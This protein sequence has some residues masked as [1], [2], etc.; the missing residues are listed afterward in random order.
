MFVC[1]LLLT[2]MMGANTPDRVAVEND[3][4]S[5]ELTA[6]GAIRKAVDKRFGRELLSMPESKSLFR[7]D[8]SEG[9]GKPPKMQTCFARQAER[10]RLEPWSRGAD[11]GARIT[12]SGFSGR[13]IEVVCTVFTR[14]DDGLLHFGLEASLPPDVTLESV[15][16]PIVM[17]GS[18]WS[19]GEK[20]AAVV[21]ATKGGIHRIAA[22]KEGATRRFDQP[23]SLAAG[24]GC[25]YDDAGGVYTAAHDG[26]GHP[27]SLM[28]RRAAAGLEWSWIHP[29]YERR[30]FS[31][32]YDIVMGGFASPQ[33]E[34]STDWRDAADLYKAW[35]AKQ[36]WCAK[37]FDRRDD[38]PAWL[39]QGPAM[40]RFTRAWLA[41]PGSV[42][43]WYR[44]Y[45]QKE[46][47]AHTP[48]IAAYW[49]WEKNGKWVGP[50]Y[51]PAYPSDDQFRRLVQLGREL[52]AHTFLWPS[53]Y[54]YSL[55]YGKRPDG[56]F[57]WDNRRQLDSIAG[58]AV[59][60]RAGKPLVR[61][62]SWL[63]GGQHCVLCP[64]DPWTIDWLNRSAVECAQHGAELVQVDQVVGGRNPPCY[65]REHDHAPGPGPWATASFR[66]QLQSMARQCRAIEPA[67]VLGFEEPN[68]WFLQEIGI[69][70]YRDCD[71]IW[72]GEEPASVFA[73]LYHEYLPTLFQSNRSQTGHDPWALAW[74][75][76][77]GQVPH[78]AP[79]LGL[80]PGPMIVDGGFERSYDEG[81][82]E[83]PRTMMFPGEGWFAGETEIDRKERHS[84]QASLKLYNQT[85]NTRA[86]AAQNYDVTEDFCPGRTYRFSAW[87]RSSQIAKPNGL[88]LKAFA[89]GMNAL[90]SWRISYPADQAQ[91][92]RRQVDFTMPDGTTVL[93]VMLVLDGGGTVWL[94]DL[95]LEEVLPDGRTVEL[96]R[97]EKPAD[98]EFMRQWLSLYQGVGRRYLLLGKMLHPPRLEIGDPVPAGTKRLPPVLHNAFEAP[99][100]SRGV[101]LVNWTTKEQNA[102]LTWKNQ[103][104]AITLRPGEVRWT[105]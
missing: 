20:T 102:K 59:V 105:E 65:S 24:F 21:G 49:G 45:W 47:P 31:L 48:L 85:P 96:Q 69:Q 1:S 56:S 103:I 5:L 100:G 3:R 81:S 36:P 97:P 9:D 101:V 10:V 18:P 53:G 74:C 26:D 19:R 64:G 80:G 75:L 87:I 73:Y 71:L 89:P 44:E 38:L 93:R 7:L 72:S 78:L 94:D 12:F 16:Y 104:R 23:G 91:W 58:H 4:L 66:R 86:L 15:W 22:W 11:R 35:A 33:T 29:C 2:A 60:D 46:F 37:T 63:R 77:Q 52:G 8:Y 54:H 62:C 67:T 88:V 27:K 14:G 30:R 55:T 17:V 28:L 84:G 79:R 41:D 99:D 61:D 98:H 40:V 32:K 57:F 43:S 25:C 76:V 83:F 34:R 13:P 70:D 39:K 90:E 82:V 68:E 95:R 51:F 6:Q 92:S 50:D 42:A